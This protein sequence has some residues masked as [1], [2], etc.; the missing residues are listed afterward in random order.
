MMF[1]VFERACESDSF[2]MI[3]IWKE[4]VIRVNQL[5]KLSVLNDLNESQIRQA[6][7]MYQFHR[8]ML[9]LKQSQI[10]INI[11]SNI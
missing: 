9:I 11:N 4:E 10:T 7:S 2:I 8:Q 5:L 3:Q 1:A 6:E